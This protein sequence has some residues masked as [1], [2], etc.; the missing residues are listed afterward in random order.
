V[1]QYPRDER[2]SAFAFMVVI[3][4]ESVYWQGRK[5]VEFL[6]QLSLW[7]AILLFIPKINLIGLGD[8]TA[9]IRLDDFVLLVVAAL[10]LADWIIKLDFTVDPVPAVGLAVVAVF[11]VSNLLNVGH[12]S[13]LYSLRLVEYLLFYWSG[14]SLVRFHY[15]F[16][17]LV[18]LLIGLNCAFIILQFGGVIGG[19]AADGYESVVS[20]PFGLSANHPAEM[21][22][23]LNLLFAALVF[24]SRTATRFWYWC[25][26]MTFCIFITGSRTSLFAHC[27]LTLV[28]VYRNSRNRTDFVLRT[29][30]ISGAL[31][32]IV[33]LVPN[34]ASERSTELLSWQNVEAVR[35]LYDSI[36]VEKEFTGFVEGGASQDAPE[37]VD[38]SLYMRGFKWVHVVKIMFTA[39]WTIWI[40]GLGPGALGPALDGGWLRLI[41]ETGVVGTLAFLS[42]LRKMY[43]LS[44]SCSMAVLALA[45]NML[46]IDS[47]NAYKVMAFLFFLVGAQVQASSR[48]AYIA[49]PIDS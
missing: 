33:A 14:K 29:T 27:L 9:G 39:S 38:V 34:S 5:S 16:S 19:F 44:S 1:P 18:K 7:P 43:R 20:R 48:K 12:S 30:V 2:D 36:P 4:A 24:G 25:A 6:S 22:A 31:I 42:L 3:I 15:D 28:Y 37:D 45:V 32:A 40:F 21:G 8:E 46:M 49:E 26:L 13:F 35:F 11:V 47:Q 17:F 23:M 10:L 41:A